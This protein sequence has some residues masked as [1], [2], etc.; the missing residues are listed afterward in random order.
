MEFV[1]G[2]SMAELIKKNGPFAWSQALDIAIS[3]CSALKH[4]HDLGIIHRD[5][6]P[7]NV[8]LIEAGQVK[9]TDFGIGKLFGSSEVT[10]AGS[11]LGTADYMPPEQ[12][13]GNPVTVRSD[14]YALGAT[15][16]AALTSR[17]PHYAKS[18]PEVLYNVRYTVPKLLTELVPGIPI[19]ISELV[20]ELLQKEASMRPPPHWS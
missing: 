15:L 13:E 20:A 12:A 9:L 2:F 5:L 10:A 7:A 8:M 18:T 14:L 19:E 16:F 17:S 6:K 4:A 11:V 3:I 1:S